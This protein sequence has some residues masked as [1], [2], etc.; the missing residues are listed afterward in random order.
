MNF[1]WESITWYDAIFQSP[2]GMIIKSYSW[3]NQ[4]LLIA[5]PNK[6]LTA[7]EEAYTLTC[8]VVCCKWAKSHICLFALY[9]LSSSG[10][11]TVSLILQATF[12]YK[13]LCMEGLQFCPLVSFVMSLRIQHETLHSKE[14]LDSIFSASSLVSKHMVWYRT[15]ILKHILICDPSMHSLYWT[16]FHSLWPY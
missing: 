1:A 10:S 7:F 16:S 3:Y 14:K 15:S 11:S 13:S 2:Q 9:L 6:V 12:W 5:L 8:H 4:D